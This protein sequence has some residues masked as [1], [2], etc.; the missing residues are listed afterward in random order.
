MARRSNAGGSAGAAAPRV[1]AA[2]PVRAARS[3]ARC[4]RDLAG[5]H[6]R[7]RKRGATAAAAVQARASRAAL[8][9]ADVRGDGR[10]ADCGERGGAVRAADDHEGCGGGVDAVA[11]HA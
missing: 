3:K 5:V 11:G 6:V 7:A 4:G 8:L 9:R 1:G 2:R 10:A